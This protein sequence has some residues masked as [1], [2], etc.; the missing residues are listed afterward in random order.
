MLKN[1][2]IK[3]IFP[4]FYIRVLEE[5]L[6]EQMKYHDFI[7]KMKDDAIREHAEASNYYAKQVEKL[8]LV[9]GKNGR[10]VSKK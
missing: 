5:R 10:F 7:V 1:L 4:W 8:K 6:K 9:R 2:M 3:Y